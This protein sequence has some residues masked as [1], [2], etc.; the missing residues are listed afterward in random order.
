M[1]DGYYKTEWRSARPASGGQTNKRRTSLTPYAP[2]F[3]KRYMSAEPE[4]E[5]R[6]AEQARSHELRRRQHQ[7]PVNRGARHYYIITERLRAPE[8]VALGA[9]REGCL[10]AGLDVTRCATTAACRHLKKPS[11]MHGLDDREL[12][13]MLQAR[14][15][16]RARAMRWSA[17]DEPFAQFFLAQLRWEYK[18]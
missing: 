9:R 12:R 10:A 11:G 4:I 5:Q 6:S 17:S 3:C 2:S 1:R 15:P 13:H 16:A 8:A 14:S 7:A 18:R